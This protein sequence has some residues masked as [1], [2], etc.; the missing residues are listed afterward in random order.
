MRFIRKLQEWFI[1]FCYQEGVPRHH[2]KW[3]LLVSGG[4]LLVAFIYGLIHA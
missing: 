4:V 3:V 1:E 2:I